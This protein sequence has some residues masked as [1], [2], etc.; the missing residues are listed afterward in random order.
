MARWAHFPRAN[1]GDSSEE[2]HKS[3]QEIGISWRDLCILGFDL[4]KWRRET[5]IF[6]GEIPNYVKELDISSGELGRF[7]L[8]HNSTET[9]VRRTDNAFERFGKGLS[10]VPTTIDV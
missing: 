2:N 1:E 10:R 5:G 8:S 6:W 4:C 3:L 7:F 9:N